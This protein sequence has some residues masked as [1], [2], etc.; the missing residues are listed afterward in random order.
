MTEF[1]W[2]QEAPLAYVTGEGRRRNRALLDYAHMGPGRSL[3]KLASVYLNEAKTRPPTTRVA[4]LKDWSAKYAW[5][6]R[7]AAWE[8]IERISLESEW[9]ERQLENRERLWQVNE[10]LMEKAENMAA[11]PLSRRIIPDG[12]GGM[13]QIV[14]AHWNMGHAARV[15]AE[16]LRLNAV[17]FGD[18]SEVT[19]HRHSGQVDVFGRLASMSEDQINAEIQDLQARLDAPG[20]GALREPDFGSG[21]EKTPGGDGQAPEGQGSGDSY[22]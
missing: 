20:P 14:P 2:A 17:L 22:A 9:K 18:P 7:I 11:W 15:V 19:E 6:A 10:R 5:Q 16:L 12:E 3:A 8:Q 13:V 4:T 1:V 21:P